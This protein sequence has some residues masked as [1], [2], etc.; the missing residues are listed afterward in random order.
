MQKAMM[1]TPTHDDAIEEIIDNGE[2]KIHFWRRKDLVEE[3]NQPVVIFFHGGGFIVGDVPS[4]S[5]FY[6]SIAVQKKITV[7]SVEYRL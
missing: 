1:P 6:S 7:A 4:V 3:E 5:S 2:Y